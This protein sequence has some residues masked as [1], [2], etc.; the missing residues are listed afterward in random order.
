MTTLW[1]QYLDKFADT[2][3]KSAEDWSRAQAHELWDELARGP[4]N[5]CLFRFVLRQGVRNPDDAEDVLEDCLGDLAIQ[6]SYRPNGQGPKGFRSWIYA[7]LRNQ[8][9]RF[10]TRSAKRSRFVPLTGF[11]ED[12]TR[13][14]GTDE[15]RAA[16]K[17]EAGPDA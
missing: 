16:D 7:C 11:D 3:S 9:C 15:R 13:D 17:I 2:L 8:V 1:G 12:E 10:T 4:L 6:R 14:L 5:R